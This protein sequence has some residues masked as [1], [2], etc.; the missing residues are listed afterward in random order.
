MNVPLPITLC[1]VVSTWLQMNTFTMA[2]VQVIPRPCAYMM[3]S[4]S[5]HQQRSQGHQV[6]QLKMNLMDNLEKLLMGSVFP[7]DDIEEVDPYKEL[8]SFANL[9]VGTTAEISLAHNSLN[10]FLLDWG[11]ALEKA[12]GPEKLPTSIFCIPFVPKPWAGRDQDEIAKLGRK[13]YASGNST[14][15]VKTSYVKI[16]F[17]KTKRYLSRN[18]QRGMEKGQFPDRKG[19][20]IDSW[21]PGSIILIIETVAAHSVPK[22]DGVGGSLESAVV[23][24]LTLTAKRFDIDGDTVIK[25]SSER[26]IIRRLRD[27]IRIW[28]KMRTL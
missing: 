1:I 11:R 15:V 21:S 23:H 28:N 26:T 9:T 16:S 20:K 10:A 8:A 13:E 4:P 14:T 24:E 27:A 17:Q 19:A 2:F 7:E 3:L 5:R 18:E 22:I 25:V 12:T 6:L